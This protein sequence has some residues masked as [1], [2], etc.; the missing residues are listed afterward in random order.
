MGAVL[1]EVDVSGCG[2]L[3]AVAFFAWVPEGAVRTA[4]DVIDWRSAGEVWSETILLARVPDGAER[5]AVDV[6]D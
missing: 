5:T 2:A 3:G 4:V 6:I 1:T